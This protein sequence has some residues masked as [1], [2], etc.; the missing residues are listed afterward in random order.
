MAPISERITVDS[1]TERRRSGVRRKLI[2]NKL[3]V[4]TTVS[5]GHRHTYKRGNK[6]TSADA[7]HRHKVIGEIALKGKTGHSHRLK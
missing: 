7:G 1:Q 2:S 5:N 4:V 6:F 3:P